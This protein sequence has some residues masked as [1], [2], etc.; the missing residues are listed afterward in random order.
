[1]AA[2]IELLLSQGRKLLYLFLP[3]ALLSVTTAV[4]ARD[5]PPNM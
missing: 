3:D 4:S 2:H 5:Q 1:M